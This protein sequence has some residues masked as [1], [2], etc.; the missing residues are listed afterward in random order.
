MNALAIDLL[1]Y[2]TAGYWG[3]NPEDPGVT[4]RAIRNG[5][6]GTTGALSPAVGTPR[7]FTEKEFA[8]SQ[9]HA[10]DILL[11][12][13]GNCGRV[14]FVAEEPSTPTCATNF[15]RLLRTNP[16]RVDARYFF[17][18]LRTPEFAAVATKFSRGA[19]IKNLSAKSTLGAHQVPLPQLEAQR[20]VASILDEADAIRAKRRIQLNLID[21][22]PQ[23]LFREYV[24]AETPVVAL[25]DIAST[26]SGG[27]PRRSD[28]KNYSGSIPWVKSGELKARH[29]RRTD[30]YISE[31][32]IATSSAKIMPEG[33]ILMA[34]YGATAGK[35][36]VLAVPAATNQAVCSITSSESVISEY[37]VEALRASSDSLLSRR[38]GGAQPNLSQ[39]IIR[40][41]RIPLLS[42]DMQRKYSTMVT[43]IHAE[44][45]R[46]AKALEADE[47]LFAALQH[48]AFRGEL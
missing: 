1:D 22:L 13:S 34:M 11:T 25:Q 14:A 39:E 15:V 38:V 21:E 10:G 17:H 41:F 12:T 26:S 42:L 31:R 48:R 37:L 5:D 24:T 16:A 27:T 32:G 45:D 6:I 40:T 3:G 35:V 29:I 2:D 47:E 19:T 18:S 9:I 33:T 4:V 44:R 46:V 8:K 30:E 20:R 28:P 36:G 7:V 43:A 23:S